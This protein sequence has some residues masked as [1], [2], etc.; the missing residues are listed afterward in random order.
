MN[1]KKIQRQIIRL[2]YKLGIYIDIEFFPSPEKV[3]QRIAHLDPQQQILSLEKICSAVSAGKDHVYYENLL[4]KF[5][6]NWKLTPKNQEFISEGLWSG[7]NSFRKLQIENSFFFEKLFATSDLTL[8]KL[9]W[10]QEHIFP[11]IQNKIST[12][13][14]KQFF[15]GN[16][17]SL[18]YF[19]WINARSI[20]EKEGE[21][22]AI[23][24][25]KILY[26]VSLKPEFQSLLI[27]DELKN[28]H[29]HNRFKRWILG[30]KTTLEKHNIS[31]DE[32]EEKINSG[33]FVITHGD[34]K[35]LNLFE[36]QSLIDWDEAGIYPAGMEPAFIY[37][38]NILH[39]DLVKTSPTEWLTQ[40]FKNLIPEEEWQHFTLSYAYFLFVFS[41]EKL[42][43]ER[44]E[45]IKKVL[46]NFLTENLSLNRS[47]LSNNI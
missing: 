11:L 34:L 16:P 23:E 13:K 20:A 5:I 19:E 21:K 4:R 26:H 17:L 44:Y 3:Y 6:P 12:P 45:E 15:I 32:I 8:E 18:A 36:N 2:F 38:R 25:S 30:A 10:F 39:Y 46:I 42:Q 24:I 9:L 27:P 47:N 40:H 22:P 31:A 41:F 37:A 14:I 28:Y 33:R 1:R 35:D 29:R 43:E 7:F